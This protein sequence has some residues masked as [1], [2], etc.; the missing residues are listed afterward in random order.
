MTLEQAKLARAA[1]EILQAMRYDAAT[2]WVVVKRRE[3][4]ETNDTV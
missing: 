1:G 2:E 3:N 4:G